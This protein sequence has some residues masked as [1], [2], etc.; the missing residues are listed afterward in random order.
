M[1]VDRFDTE[2][3]VDIGTVGV[4]NIRILLRRPN[5]GVVWAVIPKATVVGFLAQA[6]RSSATTRTKMDLGSHTHN[7]D[8]L[9]IRMSGRD[10]EKVLGRAIELIDELGQA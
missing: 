1:I 6:R 8:R 10:A 4:G 5:G 7:G 9:V 2:E 3:A